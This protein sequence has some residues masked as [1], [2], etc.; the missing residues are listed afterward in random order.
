MATPA[1][2]VN[3]WIATTKLQKYTSLP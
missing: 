1:P 3:T 2:A